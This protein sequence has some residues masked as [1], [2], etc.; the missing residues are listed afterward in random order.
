MTQVLA[1]PRLPDKSWVAAVESIASEFPTRVRGIGFNAYGGVSFSVSPNNFTDNEK[2]KL[3]VEARS[4][5]LCRV[6]VTIQGFSISLIRGDGKA[7][8]FD[9]VAISHDGNCVL[10]EKERFDLIALLVRH[11]KIF[12]KEKSVES[13]KYN[14][15]L[16]ALH[17]VTLDRLEA[18]NS[19]LVEA[20][21]EYRN[22]L[23]IEF[24]GKRSA[25]DA[26]LSNEKERIRLELYEKD[27]ALER[28]REQLEGMRQELD[29]KSNTHARRE[30]RRD[31]LREI[32]SRQERFCLTDGTNRLRRPITS[33]MIALATMFFTGL[34]YSSLE[35]HAAFM[36]NDLTRM[37]IA[38]VKQLLYSIGAAGSII[39]YIRWMN[40]WF[41]KHSHAEFDL[42]Q[43][44][45]DMERASW[46]VETSLEWKD[47]K[48]TT[49]PPELLHSLSNRLFET[50]S[51][52][53]EAVAHPI[54]NLA[55]LI[56]GSSSSLKMK[57]GNADLD[58][59]P[60]R[61]AKALEGQK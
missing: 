60:K 27:Q 28:E 32:K 55:A 13:Y 35:F 20:T 33:A 58:V 57:V 21:H 22:R 19:Q 12:D 38:G 42:K 41:D 5:L 26:E 16:S 14:A 48:G 50:G 25:L 9:Q 51:Q 23:D 30:I 15:E 11:L 4:L 2:I 40:T 8:I 29:D 46:L 31:I 54:D 45:L 24:S 1:M 49:I 34:F 36:A 6:E 61:L 10:D 56:I 59:D 52:Q 43:F 53:S 39:F 7:S 47:A 17:Q 37:S 3:I 18:L 44:E